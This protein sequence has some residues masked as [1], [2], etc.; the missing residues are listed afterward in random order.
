[1]IKFIQ[2]YKAY[3]YNYDNADLVYLRSEAVNVIEN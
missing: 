1:M 2:L 3:L